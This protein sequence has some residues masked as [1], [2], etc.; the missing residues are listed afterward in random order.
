MAEHKIHPPALAVLSAYPVSWAPNFRS[1]SVS[2]FLGKATFFPLI[3]PTTYVFFFSLSSAHVVIG[4]GNNKH[5]T[6]NN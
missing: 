4:G 5:F 1:Y 6:C 2:G 3:P